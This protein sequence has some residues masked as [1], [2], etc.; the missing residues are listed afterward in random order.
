MQKNLRS[1]NRFIKQVTIMDGKE[2]DLFF[3][4]IE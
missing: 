3:Q 2:I 4:L 1:K